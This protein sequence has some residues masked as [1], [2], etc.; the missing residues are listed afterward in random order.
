M[1]MNL[2]VEC[3]H[4]GAK[5]GEFCHENCEVNGEHISRISG[6]MQALGLPAAELFEVLAKAMRKKKPRSAMEGVL[7]ILEKSHSEDKEKCLFGKSPAYMGAIGPK[8]L[9]MRR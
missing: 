1:A 3:E 6:S 5:E 2:T 8:P 7:E 4:C 9:G